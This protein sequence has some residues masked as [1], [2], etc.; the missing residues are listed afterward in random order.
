MMGWLIRLVLIAAGAIAA[1][2]VAR[3]AENFGVVQG[4]VAVALIAAIVLAV[5]LSRRK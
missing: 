5:A 2:F 3:D 1:I 4:M